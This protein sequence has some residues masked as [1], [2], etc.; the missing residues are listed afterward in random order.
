VVFGKTLKPHQ[1]RIAAERRE[2]HTAWPAVRAKQKAQE[3][4]VTKCS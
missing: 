3:Q 4:A 2:K 1:E